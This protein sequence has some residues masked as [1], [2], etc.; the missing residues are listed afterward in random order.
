[1]RKKM[2]VSL[3]ARPSPDLPLPPK[4]MK[5]P[6]NQENWNAWERDIYWFQGSFIL[7]LLINHPPFI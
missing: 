1:M 4:E 6:W 5:E 7:V 3:T 2:I